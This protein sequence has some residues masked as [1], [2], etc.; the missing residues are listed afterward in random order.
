MIFYWVLEWPYPDPTA[1][2]NNQWRK[3]LGK[4]NIVFSKKPRLSEKLSLFG[5]CSYFELALKFSI[6]FCFVLTSFKVS[7]ITKNTQP[8]RNIPGIF[9]VFPRCFNIRD[10]QGTFGK[11]FKGKDFFKSFRWKIVLVL[12]VYDLIIT[13]IDL[14]ANSSDHEVTF[15]EY[16]RNIPRMSDSKI[17]QGY[18]RNIVKLWKYF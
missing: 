13:N 18:S 12:K 11:H 3:S 17:L 10:F 16:S 8:A 1:G 5:V 14:L 7:M 6:C 9:S 2:L 4:R 15:P